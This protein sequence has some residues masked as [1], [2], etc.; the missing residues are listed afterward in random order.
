[1]K[2]VFLGA[3]GSGKGT[4][5]SRMSE[6][7]SIPHIST[8]DIFRLNISE[9]TELGK[10]AKDYLTEGKLVPDEITIGMVQD[11]LDGVDCTD[12]FI[13]DGFPRT[14][15]QAQALDSPL[16]HGNSRVDLVINLLVSEEEI[17]ERITNRRVCSNCGAIYNLKNHP[18]KVEGICDVCSGKLILRKDDTPETLRSRLDTYYEQTSP[19]IAYY[20]KQGKLLKFDN[21]GQQNDEKTYRL[22]ELTK[23]KIKENI[24]ATASN[25]SC[26]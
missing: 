26:D 1:M 23:A 16:I 25:G 5:A 6:V 19:L 21:A 3:P 24:S 22:I 17:F 4:M 12:G 10:K 7:L 18:P 15:P 9:N 20:A 11:R 2:L 8:G 14:V 13:L